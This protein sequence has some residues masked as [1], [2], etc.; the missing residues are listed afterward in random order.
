MPKYSKKKQRNAS[1]PYSKPDA[2]NF[3]MM[4]THDD[5]PFIASPLAKSS[6]NK[7]GIL[8]PSDPS[9]HDGLN[10]VEAE[11][12]LLDAILPNIPTQGLSV[13]YSPKMT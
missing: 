10:Q 13:R 9:P 3:E 11:N 2:D 1:A 7:K 12:A 6:K 5:G 4:D 8:L